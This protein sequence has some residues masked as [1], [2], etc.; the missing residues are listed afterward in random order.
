MTR[1]IW[2]AQN[3]A[4]VASNEERRVTSCSQTAFS[5]LDE[6]NTKGAINKLCELKGVRPATA[7]AILSVYSDSVPFMSDEGLAA[8]GFPLIYTA[9]SYL[10]YFVEVTQVVQL[11]NTNKEEE[12]EEVTASQLEKAFWS[13]SQGGKITSKRKADDLGQSKNVKRR[14]EVVYSSSATCGTAE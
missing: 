3:K 5:L 10:A 6:G 1:G 12:D 8:L 11:I 7:S 4:L 9:K 13:L 14:K 2:R